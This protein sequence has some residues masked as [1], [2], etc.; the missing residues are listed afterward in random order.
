MTFFVTSKAFSTFN[1]IFGD[2]GGRHLG[3]EKR[4]R[5]FSRT[6]RRAPEMLLLTIKFHDSFEY[7]SVIGRTKQ[8]CAQLAILELRRE[9]GRVSNLN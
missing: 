4:R 3:Q 5:K 8:F 6:D 7:F 9:L 1:N 2:P